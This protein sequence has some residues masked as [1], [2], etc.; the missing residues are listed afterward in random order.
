MGKQYV[1]KLSDDSLLQEFQIDRFDKNIKISYDEKCSCEIYGEGITSRRIDHIDLNNFYKIHKD[2]LNRKINIVIYRNGVIKNILWGIGKVEYDNSYYGINGNYEI[3]IKNFKNFKKYFGGNVS[4]NN[5][6]I[7]LVKGLKDS[8]SRLFE[9]FII[10]NKG[11]ID[12]INSNLKDFDKQVLVHFN[13]NYEDLREMGIDI[14][15]IKSENSIKN[16]KE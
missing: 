10:A 4:Y 7:E 15:D 14:I 16:K 11:N 8:L 2:L 13:D 1:I 12:N 5:F 3:K 9:E 6:R